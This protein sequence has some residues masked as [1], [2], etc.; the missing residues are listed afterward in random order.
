MGAGKTTLGLE[1]AERLGRPFLDLDHELERQARATIPELFAQRGEAEFRVL[2]AQASVEI[3]R[4]RQ[5]AV[6]A[7]GGGAITTEPVRRALADHALS[8]LIEVEPDAA[9]ER[10]LGS[11]RPLAGDAG[12]F[13]A[14]YDRRR[15]LYEQ[16]AQARARDSDGVVLAAGGVHLEAASLELLGNLVPGT[17]RVALVADS[18]VA[19]IHGAA[20]QLALGRRLASTHE[21]PAGEEAKT[22]AVCERLWRAFDLERGETVVALGGGCTTDVAGFAAA[23]FLRGIDWVAVPTTLV[24]Q[25][26]AALGGK[27][28]ID[29]PGGKNLVGAFHWPVRTVIDPVLLETLPGRERAAGLAEVVKTGLLAGRP[30][31]ELPEPE[32]VRA[33]AAFK[34][35]LCLRDPHDRGPRGALNLGHTFA[36]AL[37]AAAGYS[38]L[39]HGEAVAL[40]LLAATRLSTKHLGLDPKVPAQVE[41]LLGPR[42]AAVDREA[43][44]RSLRRDKKSEGGGPR[45]VL[46]EAPGR[47]V[48]GVA[49]P[50][51][52]VRHALDE[53]IAG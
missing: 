10:V 33:C 29:L 50:D 49:L 46:L 32:L 41:E 44:W 14:L 31:W 19:G 3:L 27:T 52:E 18:R 48:L 15:P 43:A 17:G 1:V 37:E 24:G 51:R 45:L 53:L 22:A 25:V 36:H 35:A 21:L 2:E 8:V 6:L 5:P 16:A 20:A 26:D 39:S 34:T 47:P 38:G 7:L 42:P 13:R 30:L 11:G 9:W 40:G 28:A 12:E 4:S 23:T